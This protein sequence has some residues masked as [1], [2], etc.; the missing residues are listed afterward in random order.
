MPR[1]HKQGLA[2]YRKD[3]GFYCNPDIISL[4]MDFGPRGVVIYEVLLDLIYANGYY[5]EFPLNKVAAMVQRIV[6]GRWIP[7]VDLVLQVTHYCADLGMFDK[8]L[9]SQSVLTSVKIQED[10]SK[11]TVRNKVDKSKYWLL[12]EERGA[13]GSIAKKTVSVTETPISV[14]ETPISVTEMKQDKIR[15][16]K[17]RDIHSLVL[18]TREDVSCE[19]HVQMRVRESGLEGED[20]AIYEKEIREGIKLMKMKE[21][22]VMSG[23]QFADLCERLSLFE[24]EKYMGIVSECEKQGKSYKKKSHYQAILEMVAKDR[25]IQ[26]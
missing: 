25:K 17:T 21:G 8:D 16:D 13:G 24:L 10:Y 5:L 20:A 19:E 26:K 7:S 23:E 3:T 6:G 15:Q 1:P 14:T 11:S 4:L 9:L 12:E 18:S 22:V 2:F